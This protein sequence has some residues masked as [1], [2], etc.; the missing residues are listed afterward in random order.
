MAH[1]VQ[2][3]PLSSAPSRLRSGYRFRTTPTDKQLLA[4][5]PEARKK[6][7]ENCYAQN[8]EV[9]QTPQ[10][11]HAAE[12]QQSSPLN[13]E[14]IEVQAENIQQNPS[15]IITQPN[16][17]SQRKRAKNHKQ[18]K[19]GDQGQANTPSDG[20]NATGQA[21]PK[22]KQSAQVM[23]F[24]VFIHKD[25]QGDL[26]AVNLDY[27]QTYDLVSLNLKCEVT[28]TGV[29]VELSTP[30]DYS[31]YE[32]ILRKHNIPFSMPHT[33]RKIDKYVIKGLPHTT[34]PAVL[35]SMLREE[36]FKAEKAVNMTSFKTKKPLPMFLVDFTAGPINDEFLEMDSMA[37]FKVKVEKFKRNRVPP[38]CSNCQTYFHTA[39]NCRAP[40][41]CRIC[42]GSHHT[43][44]CTSTETSPKC[45]LC[46]GEHRASYKGCK[47]YK[48]LSLKKTKPQKPKARTQP[49][50]Q[51][52]N[53]TQFSSPPPQKETNSKVEERKK[54][55]KTK[56]KATQINP[57]R[58]PAE[59]QTEKTCTCGSR[60]PEYNKQSILHDLDEIIG[61]VDDDKF[62]TIAA[63]IKK[64]YNEVKKVPGKPGTKPQSA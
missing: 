44:S 25:F 7:V 32:K 11:N 53:S 36:D 64:L 51:G 48:E 63:M 23:K 22:P 39:G 55:S 62:D 2:N 38:Q 47:V 58:K 28:Q 45:C 18:K 9:L 10:N 41:R 35:V 30:K 14:S 31:N 42:A 59:T 56:T 49:S 27:L 20:E 8:A 24:C 40:A 52:V 3:T 54:L 33:P 6:C 13:R 12:L 60:C 29:K 46:S 5:S 50:A 17:K 26:L 4:P 61:M 57:I 34:D 21:S 37:G 43:S 16:T 19:N 15:E 1:S